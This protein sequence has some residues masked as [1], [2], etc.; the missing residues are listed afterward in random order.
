MIIYEE[1]LKS[2]ADL[3]G[4]GRTLPSQGFDPLPTQRVPFLYYFEIYFRL[5]DP[6][7]FLKFEMPKILNR[8]FRSVFFS[9]FC[10]P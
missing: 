10:L 2:G 9:K 1:L 5:T 4:W 7:I 8:F 6:E 3:G